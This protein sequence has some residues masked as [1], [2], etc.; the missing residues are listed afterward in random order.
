[1]PKAK[2]ATKTASTQTEEKPKRKAPRKK[3]QVQMGEQVA[4]AA[5]KPPRKKAKKVV[6]P[7]EPP[8][9]KRRLQRKQAE[10][11]RDAISKPGSSAFADW[12]WTQRFENL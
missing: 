10:N 7:G 6:N 12:I 3:P 9:K 11:P 1:M 5:Q 8:V 4:V 2:A